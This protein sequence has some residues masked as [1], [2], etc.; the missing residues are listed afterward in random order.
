[1]ESDFSL[2]SAPPRLCTRK[3]L[4]TKLLV[5]TNPG[6]LRRGLDNDHANLVV[7]GGKEHSLTAI[8]VLKEYINALQIILHVVISQFFSRAVYGVRNNTPAGIGIARLCHRF[9]VVRLL[10]R[11]IWQ[12]YRLKNSISIVWMPPD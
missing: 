7:M 1:M 5:T 3:L 4:T 11:L 9:F 2:E 10:T 12:E 6:D 8:I